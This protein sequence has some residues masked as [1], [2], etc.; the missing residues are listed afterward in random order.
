M[1]PPGSSAKTCTLLDAFLATARSSV[2]VERN[3]PVVELGSE[4]W[5][6][7]E[8]DAISSGI[9]AKLHESYGLKPTVAIVSEN[10]PYVFVLI[11]ATW[12]LEGI[13][14]TLD[15]NVPQSI[16][17]KMLENVNPAVVVFPEKQTQVLQLS[18]EMSLSF[19][20]FKSNESTIT[21][22]TRTYFSPS[23]ELPFGSFPL[24]TA[25][26][27]ALYLHTS[28]A[29]AVS[30]VKTV[31]LSHGSILAGS[32]ARLSFWKHTWPKED[33]EHLKVLGWSPWS[34]IIGLSHDIG[35]GTL[36][37]RGTYV[38]GTVPSCYVPPL[39]DEDTRVTSSGKGHL[40]IP[41][42]LL[43]T[44][45]ASTCGLDIFAG[46]PWVLEGFMRTYFEESEPEKKT[47]IEALL[48][49]FKAIGSGGAKANE[50]CIEW[51][52]MMSLKI[53]FDIGMTE[54]GGPL[55]HSTNAGSQEGWSTKDCLVS[56]ALLTLLNE[57]SSEGANEGELLI[58][59]KLI[60]KG[61]IAYD[62]SSFTPNEDG[63]VSFKTGDI[64]AYVDEQKTTLAWKGRKEDYIQMNS[65]ESLDLRIVE[66][67]LD[68][69]AY[70]NKSAVVGNNFLRGS[71]HIICAII[72]PASTSSAHLEEIVK[73]IAQANRMLAPPLRISWSRV[74]VL[75]EGEVVPMTKKGL[76]WRKKL[77]DVFGARVEGLVSGSLKGISTGRNGSAGTK[78]ENANEV[79]KTR[80]E[81]LAIVDGIV[82]DTLRIS[83]DILEANEGVTFAE[84][85]MD[86]SMSTKIV[87][88]LN[89]Q[90][91]MHLPLNT[92]HTHVD[93]AALRAA[94]LNQLG[95]SV[96]QI[97]A[98][99]PDKKAP[100]KAK[101]ERE[102]VVIVGQAMRLP[103]DI[104][105][106]KSFWEALME[107]RDD[108]MT[109]FPPSRWDHASF[110]RP[111]NSDTPPAPGDILSDKAGWIDIASFDHTFFG[112]SS[113]EAYLVAPSIRLTLEV[114]FEALENANIPVGKVKGT[115]MGVFVANQMDEGY[116]T[117][118]WAERG[119]GAYTRFYATGV[120]TST[121][122]GRLSY[123]L[124][125]HGP[126]ISIDT[127]CSSGL[128]ALDAAV[129][130]LHSG[131][132]E[133][134]IVCGANT[135]CWPGIFGFLSAQKMTS[136]NG[137]CATYT[138]EADGYVPAEGAA[139]IVL[140]TKSAAVRDGDRILAFVRATD[141]KH[142]GRSQGLVAPN[143]KAQIM[144]Q[145]ALLEKANFETQDID[146]IEAHGTGTSLGDLIEIQGIN[147]VFKSSHTPN[148]PLM[149]GA[150]KT[151]VGHTELIAGLVGVLKTL[152][153]FHGRAVPGLVQLTGNNMNPSLECDVVPIHLPYENVE[154]K[155]DG[156][157]KALVLSNGFAG[158]IAGTILEAPVDDG[159]ISAGI[160]ESTPMI[161]V[162]SAKSS[163]ALTAYLHK[164]LDFC[165]DA[166]ASLFHSVCYTS[167]V[168]R[169]HYRHR[170]A[171]V[172]HNMQDLIARIEE[173][174]QTSPSST[175]IPRRIL[176]GFP[177]QGC[178]YQGMGRYLATQYAG[179]MDIIAE[180][181]ERAS[182]LTGYPILPYLVGETAPKGLPIDHSEVAQVCI[183]TFQYAMVSWLEM[184]GVQAN[185]V[186]GHSLGEIAGCVNAGAF[187]FEIGLQFVVT[188]A[189]SLRSNPA[190]PGGMVAIAT[191]EELVL[192]YIAELGVQNRLS[193]AVYNAP[194]NNV[195]SGDL[196]AI[197]KL[198]ALVKRDG[199]RTTKLAVTQGF[200]SSS[201]A[202]GLPP[203]RKWLDD[204]AHLMK[205]LTKPIFSTVRAEEIAKSHKLDS[206]YWIDHAENA[207]RFLQ[208]A[209]LVTN[210]S[211]IDLVVD[212][213]PQPTVWSNMQG[214]EFSQKP[215]IAL[216]GKR[217]KD[218]IAAVLGGLA[219]LFQRGANIDLHGLHKQTP[220]K[221]TLTD[222]PTYPFQ[223]VFNYPTFRA[224]RDV[225]LGV[226]QTNVTP[227]G[228]APA[229]VID[230]ALFDFL[231][232]HRIEGRR[233]LPG[234]A[235]IDIF[236]GAVDS[237]WVKEF[238]FLTPLILE[239]PKIQLSAEI[240]ASGKCQLLLKSNP[241][242]KFCTGLISATSEAYTPRVIPSD[243]TPTHTM[244]KDKIYQCFNNVHFGEPFRTIQRVE[245]WDT[246]A[247]GHI[248]IEPSAN[249]SHDRI[250][251]IDACLHMFAAITA[252][253]APKH[254]AEGAYL[255][256]S[257]EDFRL[258]TKDIPSSFI[259]RYYLPLDVGRGA[260]TLSASFDVFCTAGL[261]LI[262]SQK[263][264]VAWVPRGVVH[265]E[266]QSASDGAEAWYRKTWIGQPLDLTTNTPFQTYDELLYVGSGISSRIFHILCPLANETISL[267]WGT[268]SVTAQTEE[269]KMVPEKTAGN[270]TST[271]RGQD[272]LVV[273]DLTTQTEFPDSPGWSLLSRQILGILQTI[274]SNTIKIS[275][276][277]AISSWSTSVDLYVEGLD[278]FSESK[279]KAD[280]LAGAIVGG[281]I[282]GLRRHPG[283]NLGTYHLDLPSIDALQDSQ[284]SEI[285]YAEVQAHRRLLSEHLSVSYRFGS[286]KSTPCR[287]V[288]M[289]QRVTHV[290]H[291]TPTGV[292]VIVGVDNTTISLGAAL[293]AAG[294]TQ[295]IYLGNHPEGADEVRKAWSNVPE[296]F[297]DR[298]VYKQVDI[299]NYN[300]LDN[301]ISQIQT[302]SGIIKNVLVKTKIIND[303][304]L[305][306][307]SPS[308]YEQI[309]RSST[310]LAWNL[311]RISQGLGNTLESFILCGDIGAI[312]RDT[313]E[314][315]S[316]SSNSFLEA[317]AAYRHNCGLPAT[318]LQLGSWQGNGSLTAL[319]KAMDYSSGYLHTVN[320]VTTPFPSQI[321]ARLDAG[322]IAASPMLNEEPLFAL[323]LSLGG[324]PIGASKNKL[325]REAVD[326]L[327]LNLLR[328][329]LELQANE[330]LDPNIPLTSSGG[331]SITFAQFKGQVLKELDIDIPVMYLSE[332]YTIHDM[333]ANIIETYT[334]T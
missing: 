89:H 171:C 273:L 259:C 87:N 282:R 22:L 1:D 113:A 324:P 231:D 235:M 247:D 197:D 10:H 103:G 271:M 142:D 212:I 185:A 99:T 258:H 329:A 134:A 246:H 84:L 250:R 15:W 13:V 18:R 149:I 107:Q 290:P 188:R 21:S 23:L 234:A 232:L 227:Q 65:G 45:M 293:M 169:E 245:F 94:V 279:P 222:I 315:G 96:E 162:L 194:D 115:Q 77:E 132:G 5:T 251:K 213:G 163:E 70:I 58:K 211:S 321:I 112:L 91:G 249:P 209:R 196:N 214:H 274:G 311:H 64:Y 118:L 55:F 128:I 12:K 286:S 143:V 181:A 312:L 304:H 114:A 243:V 6:Y 202:P 333:I 326:Q 110:Y 166:P 97:N 314:I 140:K 327:I 184:L 242:V 164:Y 301:C 240:N 80:D 244:L 219:R 137:R 147:E 157:L 139:A 174:L 270:I 280:V 85:G 223:R 7:T 68:G 254:D 281:L 278:L 34:H 294:V 228:S 117:L 27:T 151:C 252:H 16:M 20:T 230:Q 35:A 109:P 62:N 268:P 210:A 297:R 90:L 102:E 73:A 29:S 56:D 41:S 127:A 272:V 265:Q 263:Y 255:P 291:K 303:A 179:F 153:S 175:M 125:V 144:M 135:H 224:S 204:H 86:S 47:A 261:S 101:L 26:S 66:A 298:C 28:S 158:S 74:L 193:I 287:L 123:L 81:I 67:I 159:Q 269:V 141:V 44:A 238:R 38:F 191:T 320:A 104:N 310:V 205:P 46:V 256:T 322:K 309:I 145:K 160:P 225:A 43:D 54:L 305:D 79:S 262:S 199:I 330:K 42:Q 75:D 237:H 69:S 33:F 284:L 121:G 116:L 177:G 126:S 241:T 95:V 186:M 130:Y 236:A 267:E 59:S 332:D 183:F 148:N 146:F 72:E 9:A 51:T 52:K 167:C 111:P 63:T 257:V 264:S 154:L 308:A 40:D 48:K 283:F 200:H 78:K 220:Y 317:L 4:K 178:Q 3:R 19:L 76:V 138:N 334:T 233:V 302:S 266:Q 253:L 192:R 108:L 325:S 150:S 57:D 50:A 156:P 105:D 276:V 288:P 316:A 299:H 229:F 289:L 260:R 226:D 173:R 307:I 24:P 182:V 168:G 275:K 165:L 30:N 318:Y 215:R 328:V 25:S 170:F 98:S 306:F 313:N 239:T 32:F 131:E 323:L 208:T 31:P 17:K 152:G 92:C 11:L 88:L 2:E 248:A 221:F 155:K 218:Q 49:S 203:L 8:L 189:R 207:V 201:I 216:T 37:S 61:Y 100:E 295:I 300:T 133:S 277:M 14:A 172:A 296:I 53:V 292:T 217:G 285:I 161:F 71:A 176:F 129:Q 136:P 83:K 36:L 206:Q 124:D 93:L 195:V 106:P 60:T 122:C 198:I 39:L 187:S 82:V 120:A 190:H 331:D 119:W 319:E 180:A